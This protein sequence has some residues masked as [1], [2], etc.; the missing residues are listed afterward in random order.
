M[1]EISFALSGKNVVDA[2]TGGDPPKLTAEFVYSGTVAAQKD[3]VIELVELDVGE[4]SSDAKGSASPKTLLELGAE[5]VAKTTPQAG[6]PPG[7]LKLT[8]RPDV[9]KLDDAVPRFKVKIAGETFEVELPDLQDEAGRRFEVQLV[10]SAA[11]KRVFQ[12]KALLFVR[13]G[14]FIDDTPAPVITFITGAEDGDFFKAAARFWHQ[15]ADVVIENDGMSLE[16]IVRFLA[17]QNSRIM[18]ETGGKGWGEVNIVCHGN[19][20]QGLIKILSS[21]DERDLRITTLDEARKSKPDAFKVGPLGLSSTSRVVFRACNIG[22]RPDLLARVKAQVFGGACPVKAPKFLQV[23]SFR[24]G[25]STAPV[26]EEFAEEVLASFASP[27]APSKAAEDATLGARFAKSQA[28]LPPDDRQSFGIERPS[29]KIRKTTPH[30]N[31]FTIGAAQTE[32]LLTLADDRKTLQSATQIVAKDIDSKKKTDQFFFLGSDKWHIGKS[33]AKR[34][35]T[36]DLEVEAKSGTA[37]AVCAFTPDGNSVFIKSTSDFRAEVLA[38]DKV[39]NLMHAPS[40][41]LGEDQMEVKSQAPDFIISVG[42][43][44]VAKGKLTGEAKF[45]HKVGAETFVLRRSH[46]L[47]DGVV[48]FQ[49]FTVSLRRALRQGP[50]KEPFA[51]RK[52]VVPDINDPKHYGSSEDPAPSLAELS[53]L[54]GG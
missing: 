25:A 39:V 33:S 26:S 27:G 42:G 7:D 41:A 23:Y 20:V 29:F 32:L 1:P 50:P 22:R 31:D 45:E 5:I 53:E 16:E 11:K 18:A 30:G 4:T 9:K 8:K 52:L 48:E 21:S 36:D 12:S 15:H 19:A 35:V 44:E 13:F 47:S 2:G 10:V 28:S 37:T 14:H 17:K 54:A 46:S 49:R 40:A 24:F 43:T 3:L 34:K 51:K 38:E 6:E